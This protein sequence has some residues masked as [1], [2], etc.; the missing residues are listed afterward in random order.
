MC[1]WIYLSKI[2]KHLFPPPVHS[3][4]SGREGQ[5]CELWPLVQE[6]SLFCHPWGGLCIHHRVS[7]QQGRMMSSPTLGMYGDYFLWCNLWA[8]TT[9]HLRF[10]FCLNFPPNMLSSALNSKYYKCTCINTCT[11]TWYVSTYM[12]MYMYMYMKNQVHRALFRKEGEGKER[13][14]MNITTTSTA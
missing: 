1:I 10:L 13:K 6:D 2:V 8:S 5:C 14:R 9:V 7:R 3:S 11:C 12:Y 4:L